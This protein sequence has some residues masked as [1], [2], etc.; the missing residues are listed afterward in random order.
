MT[1]AR[2]FLSHAPED[3]PQAELVEI[4][5]RARGIPVARGR[6]LTLFDGITDKLRQAVDE[7]SVFVAVCSP[8]YLVR[9][10]CQWEFTRA[11]L[12][13]QRLGEPADRIVAVGC[14][15]PT[16][17]AEWV[18]ADEIADVVAAKVEQAGRVPLCGT[19]EPQPERLARP[20]RFVGRYAALWDLH[21]TTGPVVL[22]GKAASG[23][24]TLA[25]Q[26]GALFRTAYP[27]GVEW[28][29][30]DEH[31]P[32][33]WYTADLRR[34]A[35]ERFGVDLAGLGLDQ[36]RD[37]LAELL[38]V[39]GADVCWF[40]DGVPPGC[41][42]RRFVLPSPRVR[43]VLTARA[44]DRGWGFTEVAVPPFTPE[45]ARQPDHRT[46]GDHVRAVLAFAAVL[47]SV[48]ISGD[49]LVDGVTPV[50]GSAA[51]MVV[52]RVL[53]DL[54]GVLHP[55][56][57]PDCAGRQ[58]WRLHPL[59]AAEVR[60]TTDAAV[61]VDRAATV[62]DRVLTDP[63][64]G[65]HSLRH[66]TRVARDEA[67]APVA[68]QALLRAVAVRLEARGDNAAAFSVRVAAG[69]HLAAAWLA[70][71]AGAAPEVLREAALLEGDPISDYRARFLTAAAY[72]LLGAHDRADAVLPGLATDP[73]PVWATEPERGRMALIRVRALRARG[74]HETA[75]TL[76]E[77]LLPRIQR[78][79]PDPGHRGEWAAAAVEHAHLL[80]LTGDREAAREKAAEVEIVLRA[81]GLARHRL[82]QEAG[83]IVVEVTADVAAACRAVRRAETWYG[84]ADSLTTRLRE[85]H[86]RLTVP[87]RAAPR[88]RLSRLLRAVFD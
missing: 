27:G 9:H 29:E 37:A 32:L 85:V 70:L 65:L 72:D 84:P 56:D 17:L 73:V 88:S 24:T 40:V 20:R 75:R 58:T 50:Y 67:L 21:R 11:V 44:A 54:D 52:A 41:D 61:M 53:D 16:G 81:A 12:A 62:L 3:E 69:D 57:L 60:R 2:V 25:E 28:A 86:G 8:R 63:R 7:A 77:E 66:A 78:A 14:Q 23:K 31:D 35:A 87:E 64:A 71:T 1:T 55:V 36:A 59:V 33:D 43:T 46:G 80:L 39:A 76:V 79:C 18:R 4:A 10:A 51:P 74:H 22:T 68:R 47:D 15:D 42:A 83:A 26:Y 45:E 30:L 34:V 48:P 5:L 38:T 19:R 49:V 13:A 6:D 82:A